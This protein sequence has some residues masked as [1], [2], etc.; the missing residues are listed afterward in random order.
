[1]ND[2]QEEQWDA[3]SKSRE[4]ICCFKPAEAGMLRDKIGPYLKFRRQLDI[5]HSVHLERHCVRSCYEN[6]LSGCCSKD[7]IV[8]FWADVIINTLLCSQTQLDDLAVAL[9]EPA[10]PQKCT[11]LGPKGC[12]WQLR[13]LMCALFLCDAVK[14][15]AFVDDHAAETQW[16]ALR[17]RANEFRW[18]DKPVLFDW[19]ESHFLAKGIRSSLM[20]INTSPG[21]L[22]IKRKAGLV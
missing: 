3:L 6:H 9:T 19:L 18:P 7:G 1:M 20:Y 11:Y 17:S 10:Y 5:F 13:P 2:Y 8:T 21:L 22:R 15:K 16:E 4:A 12:R 14:T